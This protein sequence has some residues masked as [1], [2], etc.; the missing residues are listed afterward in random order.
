MSSPATL[1]AVIR[2]WAREHA[3]VF[4][5]ALSPIEARLAGRAGAA[6]FVV[7]GISAGLYPLLSALFTWAHRGMADPDRA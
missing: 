6:L 2:S 1:P 3:D 7:G 5:S 4:V